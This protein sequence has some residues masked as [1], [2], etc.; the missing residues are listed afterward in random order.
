MTGRRASFHTRGMRID[1]GVLERPA[2]EGARFVAL[3]LV[4]EAR[5]AATRLRGEADQEA[6]HDFRVGLRRLRS[7][8]RAYRPWLEASSGHRLERKLKKLTRATNASRDGEVQIAWIEGAR[9]RLGAERLR[10]GL[11][12]MIGRLE[13]ARREA[14]EP[15]EVAA[16]FE[17]LAGKLARRLGTYE[18]R[19]DP[20]GAAEGSPFAAALAALV[21]EQ[22][23]ALR[24][25]F[26]AISGA[27]EQ[28]E[29]HRARIEGKRLRYLLE[30]LRGAAHADA[31]DAVRRLKR[32]QDLLGEL[33]D[34]HVLANEL[35]EALVEVTAHRA[36]QLH[37]AVVRHG[38]SGAE[39]RQTLRDS[40][41]P[42]LLALSALVRERR[43]LLYAD[44]EREWKGGG[45]EAL[46]AEVGGIAR[47]LSARSGGLAA[48]PRTFLLSALPPR[49]EAV[50]AV[51]IEEGWLPGDHLRERL[52]R[53]RGPDGE[54]FWRAVKQGEGRRPFQA[55]EETPRE[56]YEAL[57]PLTA[58]RRIAKLRRRVEDGAL[59]WVV[60]EFLDRNLCLACAEGPPEL[61]ASALPAWLQ[62][63]V[64]R[65]V[66]DDREAQDD[67][68]PGAPAG[69]PA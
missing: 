14:G 10:P 40:P 34:G 49:A 21:A 42:G 35:A 12:H 38:A 4:S 59:T 36:R 28:A 30:P 16:R 24:K 53:T 22:L 43:E 68:G 62:P 50:A 54:R 32:L 57:W 65:D 13:A 67:P 44:L 69:D 1:D 51:E 61:A 17:R 52:R 47:A 9:E 64:E 27:L 6:L 31:R 37:G 11:D 23:D 18:R 66:T 20:E 46:A 15:A 48:R 39:V 45:L 19:V 7:A 3:A 56:V 26:D 5:Q 55:E 41:R 29:I 63:Y 60:D 8:L 58:G 2:E 25:A 33:H